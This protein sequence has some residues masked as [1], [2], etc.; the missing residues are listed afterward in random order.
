[1]ENKN[2]ENETVNKTVFNVLIADVITKKKVRFSKRICYYNI[3]SRIDLENVKYV[4]FWSCSEI[5]YFKQREKYN[6]YFKKYNLP[7][8]DYNIERYSKQ[9]LYLLPHNY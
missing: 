6:L 3:P 9:P 2:I 5:E 1:M 4:L 7:R 8:M